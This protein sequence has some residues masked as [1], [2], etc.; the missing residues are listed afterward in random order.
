M[1]IENKKK[2]KAKAKDS[3]RTKKNLFLF[4]LSIDGHDGFADQHFIDFNI[5]EELVRIYSTEY[6]QQ[7][8]EY[9]I[10]GRAITE[11]YNS[12]TRLENLNADQ[13]RRLEKEYIESFQTIF[14]ESE[15]ERLLS[16]NS[17]HY[18]EI[19][20][21]EIVALSEKKL[22]YKKSFRGWS[23]EIDRLN[24]NYEYTPA[25]CVMAC[26]WCNNAKT[27]E[28]TESEFIPVG[29]IINSLWKNRLK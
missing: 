20:V 19:S 11:I 16:G 8:L 7:P 22:L 5:S 17:C 28:F 4:S 1:D 25:N 9:K 21:A 3:F 23:L 12:I 2:Y 15:F 24:S 18:C 14:P 13:L 10:N 29:K 6:W 27:D 26:Y